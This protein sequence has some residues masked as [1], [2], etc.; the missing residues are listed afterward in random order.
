MADHQCAN[1]LDGRHHQHDDLDD[2]HDPHDTDIDPS[3]Y[4]AERIADIDSL[5]HSPKPHSLQSKRH[6]RKHSS[7]SNVK[8]KGSRS[9]SLGTFTEP[10]KKS[11]YYSP[12]KKSSRRLSLSIN[13]PS[14]TA[15]S[16]P[17]VVVSPITKLN[18]SDDGTLSRDNTSDKRFKMR[19]QNPANI[20][21]MTKG[22]RE[23][24]RSRTT[25]IRKTV[26][27]LQKESAKMAIDLDRLQNTIKREE[28]YHKAFNSKPEFLASD[29]VDAMIRGQKARITAAIRRIERL[30]KIEQD[31][32]DQKDAI[33]KSEE[34]KTFQEMSTRIF[35]LGRK[36]KVL[37]NFLIGCPDA[38]VTRLLKRRIE[39]SIE[40]LNR[41]PNSLEER[42]PAI[43]ERKAE[44][45]QSGSGSG[46][47]S[48]LESGS[49]KRGSGSESGSLAFDPS[50]GLKNEI[51][52]LVQSQV[53]YDIG[54][55]QL[56]AAHKTYQMAKTY[57]TDPTTSRAIREEN[58]QLRLEVEDLRAHLEALRP[59]KKYNSEIIQNRI[60]LLRKRNQLQRSTN[61]K[62][63]REHEVGIEKARKELDILDKKGEK[64]S[65]QAKDLKDKLTDLRNKYGIDA[66]PM[67]ARSGV[68]SA[69]SP[70]RPSSRA[71]SRP[72]TA[73]PP[74][75]RHTRRK[76]LMAHR[77]DLTSD[78][79]AIKKMYPDVSKLSGLKMAKLR[80]KTQTLLRQLLER[81]VRQPTVHK[82]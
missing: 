32:R 25:N 28:K 63:Q 29:K 43:I 50:E 16:A 49:G 2:N 34:Y 61:I 73:A 15:R 6:R 82:R 48:G 7:E 27:S 69:R 36:I 45:Q 8:V 35:N 40:R 78:I 21:F 55:L 54:A 5:S 58:T 66:L 33:E 20:P 47:G 71:S 26:H 67:T 53:A 65:S 38:E 12:P 68:F 56:D 4:L 62:T 37:G 42:I 39:S 77:S 79:Q 72:T 11:P 17:A 18:S 31:Y 75:A 74:S 64:Y 60:D 10:S 19:F 23:G 1:S 52:L 76:T 70:S 46:S 57:P 22:K 30:E 24:L 51:Q 59:I 9:Q 81:S 3:K 13:S 44:G 14:S 41:N 80:V